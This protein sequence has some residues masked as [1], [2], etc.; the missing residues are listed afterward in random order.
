MNLASR[1][2]GPIALLLGV[3]PAAAAVKG[4]SAATAK[5]ARAEIAAI[6]QEMARCDAGDDQACKSISTHY[7][8]LNA[9]GY[10][11]KGTQWHWCAR[12]PKRAPSAGR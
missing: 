4:P 9:L 3:L 5:A 12:T 7:M 2:F 8:K 10:C 1:I 11:S 6:H